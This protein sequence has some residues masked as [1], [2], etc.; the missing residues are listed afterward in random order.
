MHVE[1]GDAIALAKFAALDI[2]Q[3]AANLTQSAD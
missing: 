2:E 1:E 3:L